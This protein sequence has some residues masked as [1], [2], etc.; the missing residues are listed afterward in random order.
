M[1]CA[2][3]CVCSMYAAACCLRAA[4]ML[5]VSK[6]CLDSDREVVEPSLRVC[7]MYV[8]CMLRVWCVYCVYLTCVHVCG[9]YAACML[10]AVCCVRAAHMLHVLACAYGPRSASVDSETG[11]VEPSLVSSFLLNSC[12]R[13]IHV[14]WMRMQHED[15]WDLEVDLPIY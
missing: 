1:L 10:C 5:H 12:M 8:A 9:V 3:A 7:C 15:A 13:C 2:R 11:V 6:A 14:A 4:H